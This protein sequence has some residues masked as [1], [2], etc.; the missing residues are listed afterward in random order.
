MFYIYSINQQVNPPITTNNSPLFSKLT[1][2]PSVH[3]AHSFISDNTRPVIR[4]AATAK[5]E[6]WAN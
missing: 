6:I 3:F 4:F 5:E 1:N 2:L